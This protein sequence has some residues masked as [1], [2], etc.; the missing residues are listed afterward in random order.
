MRFKIGNA[1]FGL[2]F[3][4]TERGRLIL[5]SIVFLNCQKNVDSQGNTNAQVYMPKKGLYE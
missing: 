3:I 2:R 1:E 5:F 4:K